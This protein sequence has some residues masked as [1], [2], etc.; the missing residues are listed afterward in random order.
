MP[1]DVEKKV[2]LETMVSNLSI[3]SNVND[4]KRIV[5]QLGDMYKEKMADVLS[6]STTPTLATERSDAETDIAALVAEFDQ[7]TSK[8]P[9]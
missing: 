1:W 2:I 6:G 3:N 8:N 7:D 9:L 4:Y 5:R